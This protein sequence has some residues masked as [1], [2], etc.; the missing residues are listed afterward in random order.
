LGRWKFMSA[1]I[2]LYASRVVGRSYSPNPDAELVIKAVDMAYEQRG[3]PQNVLIH[4]DQGSHYR[5]IACRLR[6]WRYL[7]KQSM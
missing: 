7:L 3:R 2:A 4:S 5:S 6:L 1:V